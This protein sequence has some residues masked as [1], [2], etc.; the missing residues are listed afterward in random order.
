MPTSD[1][2]RISPAGP[3]DA[4]VIDCVLRASYPALLA[5]AYEPELLARAL[6]LMTRVNPRL[7]ETGTYYL[8]M[9]GGQAVGCGG[10]SFKAPG[11]RNV[12]PGVGHIRHFATAAGWTR[13]G[14]GR[15][16]YDRCEAAARE[17]GVREF[18]C[19]SSLNGE[20]FYARLGF[21]SVRRIDVPMGPDLRFPSVHMRREI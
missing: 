3:D 2:V 13:I 18:H 16:L 9:V 10:W 17:T 14:V 21:L 1:D 4:A 5:P 6:P 8:A 20:A 12:E 15:K 19:F 7:L 11:R